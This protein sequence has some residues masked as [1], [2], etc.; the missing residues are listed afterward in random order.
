MAR[1]KKTGLDYFSVDVDFDDKLKAFELLYENDGLTWILKFWQSAYKTLTGEVELRGLFG[2]L[3]AKNSRITIEKQDKMLNTAKELGLLQQTEQGLWTSNGI[4]KRISSVSKDR[5]EAIK[6]QIE[7]KVKKSKV[8]KSKVKKTPNN[9][10]YSENNKTWRNNYWHY[11]RQVIIAYRDIV[12][13]HKEILE[14]EKYYPNLDIKLS[15]EKSIKYYWGTKAG[16]KKKKDSNSIKI[17]MKETL[18]K[19]IDKNKV[20]KKRKDNSYGRDD[21]TDRSFE[22][23]PKST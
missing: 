16:W 15:L 3:M 6:R 17:N 2:E 13:N 14:L 19:N 21:G 20:Y 10:N 4:K 7:S 22:L 12:S 23:Y 1:P 8:K 11:I 5:E 9:H 18:K